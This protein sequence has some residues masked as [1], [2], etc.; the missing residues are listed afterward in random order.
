MVGNLLAILWFALPLAT[1]LSKKRLPWV[2]GSTVRWFVGF[3]VL[4]S[5]LYIGVVVAAEIELRWAWQ[6]YDLDG[7]DEL[8]P[9]EINPTAQEAMS[10]W[11]TDTGRSFAL[12]A[13][14]PA[15]IAW[16]TVNLVALALLEWLWSRMGRQSAVKMKR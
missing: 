8:S 16:T 1:W 3:M 2:E 4:S 14:I 9:Q 7:N 13:A 11:S 10:R 12:I 5:A 15:S 6:K